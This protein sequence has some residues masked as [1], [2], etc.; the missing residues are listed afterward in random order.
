MNDSPAARV[1]L[2]ATSPPAISTEC[3]GSRPPA[4]RPLAPEEMPGLEAVQ[5]D[6]MRARDLGCTS[7]VAIHPADSGPR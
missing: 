2:S 5:R 4:E 6:R 1:D 3:L 7:V